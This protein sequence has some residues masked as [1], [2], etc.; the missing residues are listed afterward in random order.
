M[1]HPRAARRRIGLLAAVCLLARAAAAQEVAAVLSSGAAPY[2]EGL[3]GLAQELGAPV[4]SFD[5]AQGEARL[6]NSVRVVVAFG[7]KAAGLR[8]PPHIKVVQ[9][10]AAAPRREDANAVRIALEPRAATLLAELKKLDPSLRR[11]GVLW[12]SPALAEYV[13]LLREAGAASGVEIVALS[14]E[15][16]SDVP[17]AL[18]RFSGRVD[19]L[20]LP[21]DPQL[22][23]ERTFP[24]F[25]DYSR[26]NGVPL[27]V[28]SEGLVEAGATASIGPSFAQLGRFAGTAARDALA[29]RPL[30]RELYAA[31]VRVVVGKSGAVAGSA[32]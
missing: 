1:I 2:R 10:L 14:P 6:P 21:C 26:L 18:R 32:P 16:A 31:D 9:A 27:F 13:A 15:D 22:L 12:L 28:S 3:Q 7:S 29:E 17:D 4:P 24:T 30:A 8:Y 20:W 19:A 5:L 11:L 23:N 25:Q